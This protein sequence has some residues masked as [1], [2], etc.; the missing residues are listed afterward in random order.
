LFD[1]TAEQVKDHPD[2]M[3]DKDVTLYRLIR[4]K[5]TIGHIFIDPYSRPGQKRAGAWLQPMVTRSRTEKGLRLP[6]GSVQANFPAPSADGKKPSLLSLGECDT[7]FHEFG[8]ALQHVMTTQDDAAVSGISGVEWDAVEIASQFMEY[9]I[10]FDK[11]T[12]YSFAKHWQ[13]GAPLPEEDYKRLLKVHDFR[14]GTVMTSQVYMSRVDMRLHEKYVDGEDPN[15]IEKEIAKET[16]PV[17]PLPQ[18]RPLNV[19]SHI[20]AGGYAAGYYSYKWSEVLSADAFSVFDA[21]GALQDDSKAHAIGQ[22]FASTLLA[23]GGG[24]APGS[25]FKDF[26]GRAPNTD[27]LLRYQG[28]SGD[29]K[30]VT[31]SRVVSEH[32]TSKLLKSDVVSVKAASL[33]QQ[34]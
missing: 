20:F 21:G 17:Q 8:H 16:L 12:L 15:A 4:N 5:K 31:A 34:Q 28:L 32:T 11:K 9:W 6:V 14:A 27:A 26:V 19:F 33:R 22:K 24:R 3:W 29:K 1:V 7:L 25:V 2:S 30:Q 13:T 10:H 23:L 18:S